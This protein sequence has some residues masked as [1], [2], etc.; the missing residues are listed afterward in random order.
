V[1]R[2]VPQDRVADV[3]HEDRAATAPVADLQVD[4]RRRGGVLQDALER[5]RLDLQRG[6]LDAVA[7][8][9]RRHQAGPAQL[10]DLLAEDAAR[11]YVKIDRVGHLAHSVR[12]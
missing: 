6:R 5:L 7:V 3:P 10:L 4:Q 1:L 11:L 8:H 2:L 9:V 12:S